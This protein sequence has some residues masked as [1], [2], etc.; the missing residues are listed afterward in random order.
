MAECYVRLRSIDGMKSL[1]KKFSFPSLPRENEWLELPFAGVDLYFKV[2][3]I[4]HRVNRIPYMYV[5]KDCIENV[6]FEHLLKDT[7]NWFS[8]PP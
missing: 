1:Y 7:E 2:Q 8:S 3:S 6:L 5:N 4:Y